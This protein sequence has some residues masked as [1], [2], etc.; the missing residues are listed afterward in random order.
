MEAARSAMS[1][2]RVVVAWVAIDELGV[3]ADEPGTATSVNRGNKVQYVVPSDNAKAPGRDYLV[4]RDPSLCLPVAVLE[5]AIPPLLQLEDFT[6]DFPTLK[7]QGANTTTI[8]A[9]E[10]EASFQTLRLKESLIPPSFVSRINAMPSDSLV[11]AKVSV[12]RSV[13]IPR[14]GL[15]TSYSDKLYGWLWDKLMERGSEP[16]ASVPGVQLKNII[17]VDNPSMMQRFRAAVEKLDA[18]DEWAPCP[19]AFKLDSLC[20]EFPF[21]SK[22]KS[23]VALMMHATDDHRERVILSCGFSMELNAEDYAVGKG[24]AFTS[25]AE[26]AKAIL[27]DRFSTVGSQCI[28][29]G[30]GCITFSWVAIGK[31]HFTQTPTIERQAGCTTHFGLT[32]NGKFDSVSAIE[33]RET[34]ILIAFEP[35][36]CIP[37]AVAEI[38]LVKH[39]SSGIPVAPAKS[40]S[41]QPPSSSVAP[42][43]VAVT[44]QDA[45]STTALVSPP[46]GSETP[47]KGIAAEFSLSGCIP[48]TAPLF[49]WKLVGETPQELSFED[50]RI[51]EAAYR[52]NP[53]KPL[54]LRTLIINL[55]NKTAI[56]TAPQK[57][58]ELKLEQVRGAWSVFF[59]QKWRQ[60]PWD[61]HHRLSA[62][63]RANPTAPFKAELLFDQPGKYLFNLV[64]MTVADVTRNATLPLKFA[65]QV[66]PQVEGAWSVFWNEKWRQLPWELNNRLSESYYR[67]PAAVVPVADLFRQPGKYLFNL[68]NMTVTD[69]TRKATR[70][71]RLAEKELFDDFT[72]DFPT[73]MAQGATEVQI[74]VKDVR[75]SFQPLASREFNMQPFIEKVAAKPLDEVML[76]KV[77]LTR[78]ITLPRGSLGSTYSD[79][80]YR[81]VWDRLGPDTKPTAAAPGVQ[82]KNIIFISNPSTMQCFRDA[83]EKLDVTNDWPACPEA[84]K[85]ET[86]CSEHE[87]LFSLNSRVAL[88]MHSTDDD[89]ECVI[90]S[91][92]FSMELNKEETAIGKGVPFT[93]DAEYAKSTIA[94]RIKPVGA[95]CNARGSGCIVLSWVVIGK[96]HFT[97]ERVPD[98]QPGCTTHFAFTRN[99][100]FDPPNGAKLDTPILVS[101]EPGLCYPFAVAEFDLI[102][103]NNEHGTVTPAVKKELLDNFTPQF[104][105]L[106]DQGAKVMPVTAGNVQLSFSDLLMEGV[107]TPPRFASFIRSLPENELVCEKFSVACPKKRIS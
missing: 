33:K 25:N 65:E 99:G 13:S 57:T 11:L 28:E 47:K 66:E 9:R 56:D 91:C 20:G 52:N 100:V 64:N 103:A 32:H 51:I 101:F 61:L 78:P 6:P 3:G 48:S 81:W 24:I 92:G 10:V 90:L 23:R 17:F 69:S 22:Y 40:S 44:A 87:F 104:Q 93:S 82:L 79:K 55:K 95:R 27:L 30:K 14:E 15:G 45:S 86:L 68:K 84:S 88:M 5:L 43:P 76:S 39:P 7:S 89:R 50:S 75:A 63:Y 46:T 29:R 74:T 31:P 98:R 59:D 102:K 80:W 8:T 12:A 71:V 49:M 34:P 41:E 35:S 94:D 36:L 16:T 18:T 77:H 38:D 54:K 105:V 26:Y 19:E 37:F 106:M 70:T 21:L 107:A 85:L 62:S 97:K 53:A 1:V 73:L 83:V 67:N 96:P 4:V 42:E 2:A 72:A 60:L 58:S